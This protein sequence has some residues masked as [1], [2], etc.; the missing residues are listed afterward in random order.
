MGGNKK[1]ARNQRKRESHKLRYGMTRKEWAQW[2]REKRK[3]GKGFEIDEKI[4]R[5]KR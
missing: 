1:A 5:A 3:Q 2:K 4:K